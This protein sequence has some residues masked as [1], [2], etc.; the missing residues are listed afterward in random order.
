MTKQIKVTPEQLERR[1]NECKKYATEVEQIRKKLES[2]AKNL[3]G[4]WTG[5]ASE[6]FLEQFEKVVLPNF[7]KA[8][9]LLDA[10][11]GGASNELKKSAEAFRNADRKR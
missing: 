1:A 3:K 2:L 10:E 7:K 6:K 8:T 11:K 9:E 5:E 4:E